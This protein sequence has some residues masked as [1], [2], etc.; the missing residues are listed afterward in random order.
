MIATNSSST[1][2]LAGRM[3]RRAAQVRPS[4]AAVFEVKADQFLQISDMAGKQVATFVAWNRHD[5]SE[6]LSTSETRE[7]N[8]ALMLRKDDGIYSNRHNRM[9][10]LLEDTVGRHDMLFPV[11]NA[12]RYEAD[13][14]IPDH[15]N[16]Q[17]N[18]L[19]ALEARGHEL[20]DGRLPD[21]VHFFMYVAIKG[22]GEFEIRE[23]LSGRNDNVILRAHMDTLVV[24]SACPNDQ[25]PMTGFKPTDVLV[26]VYA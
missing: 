15:P 7:A 23:P 16:C 24:V 13:Y 20:P 14:G 17:D 12:Q 2:I 11:C 3:A 22:R 4:Q 25:S 1:N 26:R 8:N 6:Y 21:A 5:F 9:F 10:T 18:I 19:R